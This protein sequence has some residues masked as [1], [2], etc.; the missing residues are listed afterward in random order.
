[1][2]HPIE[3]RSYDIA[4]TRLAATGLD[5]AALAPWTRAVVERVVH[6][7][8]DITYATDLVC[9]EAALCG[10]VDALAAGA[11]IVVDVRMTAAGITTGNVVC[12]LGDV[13][14]GDAAR[15]GL[16][17][18]AAA[19]GLALDEVGPGAVWVI[20]CAPTALER[21][22]RVAD[23]AR[24]A[25]V[26]GLPVGFVGAV[27]AKDALRAAGLPAISNRSEKGGAAVAA[28]AL[29]ALLYDT[30]LYKELRS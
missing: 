16:T 25:L 1:M 28:A 24:P 7:S 27:E 17:R 4:R 19:V 8:A 20:G 2:A 21:L 26:I 9:D 22:L 12:R 15:A 5:T 18:S 29:N 6:A 11:P 30:L 3:Q 14:A 13:N 10:A 23:V